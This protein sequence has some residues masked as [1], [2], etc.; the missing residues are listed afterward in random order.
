MLYQPLTLLD[1][2]HTFCGACLKEWFGWQLSSVRNSP[3]SI[4]PGG[5]PYTCPSCR[6]PV[7][8][9]KH[10]ATVTTLLEMFLAATP[11]KGKDEADK[12]EMRKKYSPGDEVLA[13][14]EQKEKTL[15]ERRIEYEDR[16][17]MDQVRDM[18][19]REVGVEAERVRNTTRT[20]Q[21]AER[22][23]DNVPRSHRD[24]SHL[25]RSTESRAGEQVRG[26]HV[27]RRRLRDG[28]D[29][30]QA[31]TAT[32]NERRRRRSAETA[33][34]A[35]DESS[36]PAARRIEHQS[37]LRSLISSSDI[38]SHEMEEEILRQI[39]EE[40][41]LDGIDLDNIDVSQEDQISERIA[42]A[43]RRRQE[44]RNADVR[45]RRSRSP[46]RASARVSNDRRSES[47]RR[48]TNNSDH[49]TTQ[50]RGHS[51]STSA[52]SPR[53][54][55]QR[56][57]I[58]MSS[59]HLGT[60][61]HD[62]DR[63]RRRTASSGR[64]STSPIPVRTEDT[65]QSATRSLLDLSDGAR[66]SRACLVG[67]VSASRNRS[68]TDI[69]S[70]G[71]E[72][73]TSNQHA[74][75]QPPRMADAGAMHHSDPPVSGDDLQRS[76]PSPTQVRPA[77]TAAPVSD[78]PGEMV[79]QALIPAPLTPRPLS[80]TSAIDRAGL[81]QSLPRPASLSST[82]SH[83]HSPLYPEPFLTCSSCSKPH[84]EYDLH[85]NCNIC[86]AGD[87]NLC[88]DC[89][90]AGKG[91]LYW[92]GFGYAAWSKWEKQNLDKQRLSGQPHQDV[93]RPH[94][95]TANRFLPPKAPE[96]GAANGRQ[97]LTTEDP[98]ARLQSGAFCVNCFAWANECYWRCEIC[99]E[100]DW[101]FC[102]ICVNQGRCCTHALL[103]LKYQP[104]EGY[105]PAL[106]PER[107]QQTPPSATIRTGPG[108]VNIGSFKPLGFST[109]CDI[110]H[111]P[112][113]PSNTR[114]H[115]FSC[116]STMPGTLPGDYDVCTACYLKL[117]ASHR[118]SGENGHNGWRRCLQGHRMIVVGFEDKGGGQR[119]TVVRDLVGGRALRE[120]TVLQD[121]SIPFGLMQ[122]SWA[123]GAKARLVT[124]DVVDMAPTS[125][126]AKHLTN[127]FP[128][129]GGT[130]MRVLA[131]WSWY[132]KADGGEN[133]LL[134]P[135]GA[136]IR[137]CVDVNGDWFWGV[138]MGAKA[139]FPAPYVRIVDT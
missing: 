36:R 26:G 78:V 54:G 15:R 58:S 127:S 27:E 108:I 43:F 22:V 80:Q 105:D 30:L 101:G 133:E 21:D 9:T 68:A 137:E 88:L 55:S 71:A 14:V 74:N 130:G 29:V 37:S 109:S 76:D 84:I 111:Y 24:R 42:Q 34:T 85:Y 116:T 113:Q 64:S 18:S 117:V 118:I 4:P 107:D 47:T 83:E 11:E 128:I 97:T 41:L 132:P 136:E 49:S 106:A 131:N 48:S 124:P 53:E 13:K 139:L 59:A 52:I 17:L 33:R 81:L 61:S 40:G 91:C 72:V 12:A 66:S 119:R 10:N 79:D 134:F 6:S 56:P 77:E 120:E 63:R 32:S 3:V 44:T 94:F 125:S 87:W 1:C 129:D 122:W 39:H 50:R 123:G 28:A 89:Y 98:Q 121:E 51:R 7:R 90:R 57:P 16:R 19:L 62:G 86:S 114:Y 96:S 5:T 45:S 65:T 31:E 104:Y 93:E 35:H 73:L 95:L 100:G 38:D 67:T 23:Q 103:P 60:Q 126:T 8:D 25:E 46:S 69:A 102:N 75:Q 138:Y 20:L 2:L 112:V 115:C 99:N 82:T 92:F 70:H 110:C 135:K